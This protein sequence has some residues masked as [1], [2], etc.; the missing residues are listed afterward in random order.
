MRSEIGESSGGSRMAHKM[1]AVSKL[2]PQVV[3]AG[4][5]HDD[6]FIKDIT[7]DTGMSEG[8]AL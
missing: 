8:E 6:E 4:A 7:D 5:I 1:Q 3:S 2:A